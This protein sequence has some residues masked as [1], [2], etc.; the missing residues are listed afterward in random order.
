MKSRP[1]ENRS[2]NTMSFTYYYLE[3]CDKFSAHLISVKHPLFYR[4]YFIANATAKN[5]NTTK[6]SSAY[7][8]D[9]VC[10]K[11]RHLPP[12]RTGAM[13]HNGQTLMAS[14]QIELNLITSI[15]SSQGSSTAVSRTRL[16]HS[17]TPS[18]SGSLSH[19]ND[20]PGLSRINSASIDRED[21]L[22]PPSANSSNSNAQRE[23]T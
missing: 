13:D 18:A 15:D 8:G 23:S 3:A 5:S 14:Q 10:F 2:L 19:A 20:S 1:S 6:Y 11:E 9:E 7:S 4:K 12:Y 17:S 16:L 21:G 22:L